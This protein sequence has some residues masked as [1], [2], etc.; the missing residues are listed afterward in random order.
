MYTLRI[1]DRRRK[2]PTALLIGLNLLNLLQYST[3]LKMEARAVTSVAP[4]LL[5][6]E[7]RPLLLVHV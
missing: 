6:I 3:A 7:L 2:L 1:H 4:F 5:S